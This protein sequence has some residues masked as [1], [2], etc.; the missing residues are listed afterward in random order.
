MGPI[1]QKLLDLQAIDK[2]LY[3]LLRRQKARRRAVDLQE[4]RIRQHTAQRDDLKTKE[5]EKRKLSDMLTLKMREVEER[6][7]KLRDALNKAR[8]NKEYASFLTEIN[9]IKADNARVEDHGITLLTDIETLSQQIEAIDQ[10][11]AE[12][13]TRLDE[14]NESL[15]EELGKLAGMVEA[16]EAKRDAATEG[17]SLGNLKIFN[18][19][20]E[21][22]DGE[23]MAPVDQ[24]G[25]KPPYT[26]TCGGCFMSLTPEHANALQSRDEVRQCDSCHRILYVLPED[27]F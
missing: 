26:Y 6:T 9:T 4:S 21:K 12:E 14:L 1:L 13:K 15:G 3:K 19:L 5:M 18:A 16:L 8:N 23:A 11:L 25:R 20:S 24:A 17:I 27:D 22:H 10:T 2:D 7:T